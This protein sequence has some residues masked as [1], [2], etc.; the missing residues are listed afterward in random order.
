MQTPAT[1]LPAALTLD[2]AD[3]GGAAA[4]KLLTSAVVPRPIA[5][6]STVDGEGRPNLAPFSYFTIASSSPPVLLFCPQLLAD[7][8]APGGVRAKDTLL[9]VEA[10]GEVVIHVVSHVLAAAMNATARAWPPGVSEFDRAGITAVPSTRVQP[11]RVAEAP[12]AFECRVEQVIRLG[13]GP[14][15]G[16]VV[17]ARV[18]L[19]HLAPGTHNGRYALLDGLDPVARLGGSDYTR[20]AAG[21]FT[22]VRPA[23][24]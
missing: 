13:D 9:N 23:R 5:W 12:L 15:A 16:A 11:P 22:L 24:G 10:T 19:A 7:A 21:A 18:L 8:E 3:L 6:A 20:A 14:G 4:Y 2:L 17:L 1:D